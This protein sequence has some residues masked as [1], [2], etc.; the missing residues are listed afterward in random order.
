MRR[1]LEKIA[2]KCFDLIVV[3][4]GIHGI[5][6]ARDAALRGLSVALLE[7]G[8]FGGETS[9]N[10]LK[11]VHGGLRYVQHLDFRRMR[12]SVLE[13][14]AWLRIAPH[15]VRPLKII[16]LTHG[17]TT[18]GPEALWLATRI[19]ELIGF[20]RNTGV[21]ER[22]RIPKGNVVGRRQSNI[23]IPD[24]AQT[25]HNGAAYWY[26]GQMQ[27]ADRI[28]IECV[29]SA[30]AA[31]TI[32]ANY[33]QVSGLLGNDSRV[34]GVTVEDKL[35]GDQFDVLAKVTVNTA[36]PWADGLQFSKDRGFK[37]VMR[38]QPQNLNMNI[39]IGRTIAEHAIGVQSVRRSDSR[40]DEGGRLFFMTPWRG[41]SIIGTTH[42]PYD[43]DADEC[44]IDEARICAFIDEVN[45]AY[46]PAQ[47]ERDEVIYCHW[48]L[49]P[50]ERGL[51]G[52][53]ARRARHG[54]IIDHWR[55]NNLA[56]LISVIG[57]KWTTARLVAE[58]VVDI[59]ANLVGGVAGACQTSSK[60]L[61]GAGGFQSCEAIERDIRSKM[62]SI[63]SAEDVS[64]L[65]IEY[66]TRWCEVAN[67][68]ISNIG[69]QGDE[70]F[71]RKAFFAV[72]NEMA[73][74]LTDVLCRRTSLMQRG[75]LC[76]RQVSWCLD[77]MASEFEWSETRK[78]SEL[79]AFE[80]QRMRH[81][82]VTLP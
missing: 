6:V 16:M 47:I 15:L 81:H 14:R 77:M 35:T 5:C 18:R 21:V 73:V 3:G 8:D 19:H 32:A 13:R 40:V 25:D 76:S 51:I 28:M 59:A 71:Q 1:S 39:V 63:S 23:L 69:T 42:D 60:L 41:A 54:R 53:E 66:G 17:H 67:V 61:C 68:S 10:S 72:K 31:G 49:T 62:P 56:G 30:V 37:S 2:G 7:R 65:A 36:G 29:D 46:P 9:H 26:D 4:G 57:V 78:K 50:G 82:A 80:Q 70:M 24:L 34:H 11:I 27:D 44:F 58:N 48:G 55:E 38:R 43:G 74:R 75:K 12:Q 22:R 33:V 64:D 45:V 52:G 20:D 79:V